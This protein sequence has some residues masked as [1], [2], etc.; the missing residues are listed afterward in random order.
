MT[1]LKRPAGAPLLILGLV[2]G[3]TACGG[4][5]LLR[6][7]ESW[8]PAAPIATA[9]DERLVVTLD[10]VIFRAGPGSWAKNVDWD[11]YVIRIH[12]VGADSIQV[13]DISVVDSLG[14]RVTP[15]VTRSQLVNGTRQAKRR[16]KGEGIKVQAGVHGGVLVGAGVV[17]AAGTSG[18]G[19]AAMAGGGAALGAAAIVVAVPVLMVGGVARGVNNS[20]VN[21]QIER[22]QTLLPTQLVRGE[23]KSA[24]VFFPVSPSP[25]RVE[26]RYLDAEEHYTLI[27]DTATA[28]QGLHLAK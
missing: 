18:I 28:L 1:R 6:N 24:H 3:L 26:F 22:R 13:D 14:A 2:L 20:K 10:A 12:N 15:G 25:L 27:L 16:Y 19:T 5:K 17:A 21:G 4:T 11:E 9:S 7:P 23:E 8:S